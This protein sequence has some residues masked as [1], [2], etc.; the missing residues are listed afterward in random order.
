MTIR[1][2]P[3]FYAVVLIV[4]AISFMGWL[5]SEDIRTCSYKSMKY[6]CTYAMAR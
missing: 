5:T 3:F 6:N 2:N 1:D 4:L